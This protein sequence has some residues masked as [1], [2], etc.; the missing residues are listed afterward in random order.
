[1][2]DLELLLANLISADD[3]L[4][5]GS[6]RQLV[7]EREV[8]TPRLLELR[9]SSDVDARWWAYCALGQMPDADANWFLPGLDDPSPDVRE[10]A[11]MA[12]CHNPDN[13]AIPKLITAL[14]DHDRMVATLSVRGLVEIGKD[15][16]PDLISV[17][18]TGTP[19]ARI[20]AA[21]ALSDIRD[22]RAIPVF[23][24]ALGSDSE[25]VKFWAE[26][27]LQNLG[28]EMVYFKPG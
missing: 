16:V 25:L 9:N 17:L 28:S 5:E 8:A 3:E 19:T 23:M 4:A 24:A 1:M 10:C 27:G 26:Q 7:S 2:T 14:D 13:S 6:V 18:E 11:A 22:P 15:A 21:H 12:L 20:E